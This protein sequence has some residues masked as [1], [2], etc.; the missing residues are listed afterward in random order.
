M[1]M[2][3]TGVRFSS[4]P[5][6]IIIKLIYSNIL[7]KLTYNK[8]VINM[9]MYG[10]LSFSGNQIFTEQQMVEWNPPAQG[11]KARNNMPA[12]AFLD[13]AHK[14]YPYKVKRNGKWVVSRAGVIAAKKRAA[15]QGKTALVAK[16]D[17]ILKKC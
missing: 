12:S 8:Q 6:M 3:R 14:K 16:A 1:E 5:P 2:F 10:E 17:R 9:A 15:Q 11:T 13:P 7:L 4:G